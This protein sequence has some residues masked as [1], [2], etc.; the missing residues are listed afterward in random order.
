MSN[1]TP[2]G[3]GAHLL[4]ADHKVCEGLNGRLFL[5]H[6]HHHVL[7]Q[8]TGEM[9][10]TEGQLHEWRLLLESRAGWLSM[11]GVPYFLL[12]P[13][14]AHSVY[15]EDLPDHPEGATRPVL[16]LLRHLVEH[17]SCA[18]LEYPLDAIVAAKPALLYPKTD[19]HWTARGAFVAYRILAD[20][21]A[22]VVPIHKV[23]EEDVVYHEFANVGELGFKMNPVRESPD[24]VA[25]V[26]RPAAVLVMDNLVFNT[27]SLIETSCP[28]A[29]PTTCLLFGDSYVRRMLPFLAASFRRLVF[30]QLP[31]LDHVLIDEVRP[32]LVVS[33]VN[34]RFMIFIHH[35]AGAATLQE[36]ASEKVAANRLR[37]RMSEWPFVPAENPAL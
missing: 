33:V 12:V 3:G 6:D 22:A 16:Q 1:P 35:D 17:E 37:E 13:P 9:P 28:G 30:A 31:T 15:P 32:D 23:S 29:P 14:N 34:E 25:H 19:S 24:V 21:I 27:G 10:F 2:P 20:Q 5:A 36:L 11:R 18:P 8:H 26:P 4:V 7:L